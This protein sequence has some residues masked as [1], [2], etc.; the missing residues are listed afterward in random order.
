[1][2]KKTVFISVLCFALMVAILS[3]LH[4]ILG[5]AKTPPGT[6]YLA[7]GHYYLDYYYYL[8][9]VAQ[10][11]RGYWLPHQYSAIDDPS[12]YFQLE[13]YVLFGQLFRIFH[14]SPIIVYW[15]VVFLMTAVL[16]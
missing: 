2:N 4:V 9:F 6:V 1:M 11:L 3:I 10:G 16:P 14:L 13:P 8:Q 7:T 15:L 5:F 12:I